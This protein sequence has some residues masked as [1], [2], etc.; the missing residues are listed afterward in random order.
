M[1]EPVHVVR[2]PTRP[3]LVYDG[4]CRFCCFWV[5]RWQSITGPHL[6]YRPFQDPQLALDFPEL[7]QPRLE[8]A[9]HLVEVNGAVFSGAEAVFRA[10][11]VNPRAGGWLAMY[12]AL[13]GAAFLSERT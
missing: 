10:L 12:R 5:R 2:P 7:A 8:Q 13:P 1:I 9:V 6:E 11:A 4:E 3:V